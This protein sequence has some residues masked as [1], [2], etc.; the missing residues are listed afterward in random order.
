MN[1]NELF[2]LSALLFPI[3]ADLQTPSVRITGGEDAKITDFPGMVEIGLYE[4][5]KYVH[6]CGGSYVQ[7]KIVLTAAHCLDMGLS[8]KPELILSL[9][10]YAKNNKEASRKS[11]VL[12]PH[13]NYTSNPKYL[14]DIAIIKMDKPFEKEIEFVDIPFNFSYAEG[15]N[16]W[17]LGWGGTQL[18]D[19]QSNM[20]SASVLQKLLTSIAFSGDENLF[21]VGK[22]LKNGCFGDSGGPVISNDSLIG[23]LIESGS[24]TQ[25]LVTPKLTP[26]DHCGF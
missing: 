2:Y 18:T 26:I 4:Q 5:E 22:H 6:R 12:L 25:L 7:T 16:V 15:I 3:L 24:R 9:G 17:I 23:I 11:K 8:K 14:H 10:I 13:P 21:Y 20:T 1:I 19:I